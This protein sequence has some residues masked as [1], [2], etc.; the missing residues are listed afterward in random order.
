GDKKPA[1]AKDESPLADAREHQEEVEKTLNDLLSRLEPWSSTREIKA[2]AKS[3][4]QEQ[5]RLNDELDGLKK[6]LGSSRQE[7]TDQQKADLDKAADAQKKLEERTN[8]LLDKMQ[9]MAEDRKDK[10]PETARE[11]K[12][13]HEQGVKSNVTGSM[14]DAQQRIGENRLQ[15]AG[16][17][18]REAADKLDK[19]V[20]ELEDRREAELDRLGEKLKG[21]GEPPGAPAK[22]P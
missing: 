8:Q 22:R 19:L 15:E 6:N 13:A 12:N 20:K 17:K 2:E 9:R 21:D 3:L 10:D 18:Q 11:L 5:R 4:L 14:K 7:L 1:D 16:Q